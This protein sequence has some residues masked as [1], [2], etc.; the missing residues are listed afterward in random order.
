VCYKGNNR[1]EEEEIFVMIRKKMG[2]V[3]KVIS[4]HGTT[5]YIIAA[6]VLVPQ[7][8]ATEIVERIVAVVNEEIITLSEVRAISIPYIKKMEQQYSVKYGEE[9]IVDTE[10]RIVDQLIDE[11]LVAQEADRLEIEVT[12]KE[13]EMAVRDVKERNQLT[14][15]QFEQALAEDGMT[16]EDYKKELTKQ[17]KKMRVM[18]Q[19]V[20]AKVQ[21]GKKEVDEYYEKHKSEFN[22]PPEVRLQQILL[23]VSPEATDNEIDQ[24]RKKAN[25]I[26]ERINEG[27]N[28]T[29]MVK[30]YSQDVTAAAGGDMGVF[31]QGE[32]FPALDEAAFSLQVGEVSG[33]IQSPRGFHILKLLDKKDRKKMTEEERS[34]E[35]DD[36]IYNQKVEERFQKWIKELREKSYVQINL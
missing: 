18:D 17:M 11:K 29:E 15:T 9:E 6:I 5:V 19:E 34:E 33:V 8:A 21:V 26:R 1:E 16:L 24:V 23:I 32:L 4:T 14:D 2:A 28:F 7:L 36:I 35:I 13:L 31:L 20:R 25:R 12:P 3:K 27:E 10:K 30:L 22:A